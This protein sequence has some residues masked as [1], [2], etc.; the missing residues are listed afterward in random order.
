MRLLNVNTLSL[1]MFNGRHFPR[2]AILSHTW[3]EGEEVTFEE[4]GTESAKLKLGYAKITQS[5]RIAAQREFRYIWID[6]CCIDKR[7]SAELS[8]AINSM[9]EW[10][11]RSV[12]CYAYLE[13]V[14]LDGSNF[15]NAKWFTRG[16][17]LQEL[18][19]PHKVVFYSRYW[20]TLGDKRNLSSKISQITGIDKLILEHDKDLQDVSVARRMSWASRRSTTRIED[21]AYC[22]LGIFNVNMPLLYGEGDRAF[23]RLQE[24]IVKSS[25]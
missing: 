3:R 10:Y 15:A 2:Y 23:L 25:L 14:D 8:E 5:C 11:R 21:E 17:T 9:F 22:L 12:V 24:E 20:T 1:E 16:W 13:D 6:T 7:N 18:V 4:L 19:A